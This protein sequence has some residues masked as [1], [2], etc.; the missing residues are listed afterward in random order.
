MKM[1]DNGTI[2]IFCSASKSRLDEVNNLLIPSLEKQTTKKKIR[3]SL[4]DYTGQKTFSKKDIKS[5]KL[6]L[7]VLF[8][9]QPLGF[10]ESHNFAF[11]KIKPQ[12]YF[13][14]I[15]PDIY[16]DKNCLEELLSSFSKDVGL[17]EARQLPF[18]HPKDTPKNKTFETNWA[19]GCCLLI[20]SHFFEKVNGFDPNYWMYLED[21]DLSWKAWINDYKVLQNPRAI[22]NHYTGLYFKY[23]QNS[24]EIEDFWSMRN[25]L[26]I[27]YVYFGNKGVRQ[28]KRWINKTSYPQ[29]LI[30]KAIESFEELMSK[31]KFERIKIPRHCQDK[32]KIYG[33]NK[34]SE[35]PK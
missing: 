3:L 9:K 31:N 19:S 28:A 29:E 17:V 21:V 8:P 22:V 32:I 2:N 1:T 13:L 23:S 10:G 6:D 18:T 11:S 33:Y 27:S 4:I 14:I 16:M 7:D 15:N 5:S 24:Y 12:K 25:F 20:N 35:Y 30:S 26:Y 34:F